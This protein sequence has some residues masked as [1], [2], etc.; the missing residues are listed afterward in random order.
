M[1]ILFFV[2]ASYKNFYGKI[3]IDVSV[4]GINNVS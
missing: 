2:I 3:E 1:G 4:S